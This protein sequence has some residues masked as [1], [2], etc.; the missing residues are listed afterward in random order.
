MSE[1]HTIKS[2]YQYTI[3]KKLSG[4]YKVC[5]VSILGSDSDVCFVTMSH[6]EEWTRAIFSKLIRARLW[7]SDPNWAI[8]A[9]GMVLY[10]SS[11]L[12]LKTQASS[13]TPFHEEFKGCDCILSNPAFH[14]WQNRSSC[15]SERNSLL[16]LKIKKQ[17]DIRPPGASFQLE[18]GTSTGCCETGCALESI[19]FWILTSPEWG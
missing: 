11:V 3:Q 19:C 5:K 14:M 12:L 6:L 16:S 17:V 2:L 9:W 10:N 7:L 15:L 8:G 1:L 18:P 4:E 13:I